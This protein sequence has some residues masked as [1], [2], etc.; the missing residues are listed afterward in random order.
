MAWVKVGWVKPGWQ[1]SVAA[2]HTLA[3]PFRTVR[4]RKEQRLIEVERED[5]TIYVRS[6]AA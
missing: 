5:R 3:P 6:N 1:Q 4:E 2:P